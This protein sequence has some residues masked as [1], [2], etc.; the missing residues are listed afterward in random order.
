[1]TCGWLCIRLSK[2]YFYADDL[3]IYLFGVEKDFDGMISTL[4]DDL[5]ELFEDLLRI[6]CCLALKSLS[7]DLVFLVC[8]RLMADIFPEKSAYA[9]Y[10]RSR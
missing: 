1:M 4:Y 3:Q 7:S 5:A 10:S 2:F 6:G 9:L 8:L